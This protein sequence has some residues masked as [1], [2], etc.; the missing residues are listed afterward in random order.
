MHTS[1]KSAALALLG[2]ANIV[3]G[4]PKTT[5]TEVAPPGYGGTT[6]SC[7]KSTSTGYSTGQTTYYTTKY[8]TVYVP[9]TSCKP[10]T[11]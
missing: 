10:Y 3:N 5:T 11:T 7:S 1:I 8:T 6:T 4:L 2:L 9:K